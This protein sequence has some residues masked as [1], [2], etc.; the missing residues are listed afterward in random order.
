MDSKMKAKIAHN[1]A[2]ASALEIVVSFTERPVF[3]GGP[4]EI[5]AAMQEIVRQGGYNVTVAQLEA[6]YNRIRLS[7]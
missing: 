1:H 3:L 2:L 4:I 5:D 6:E 7:K